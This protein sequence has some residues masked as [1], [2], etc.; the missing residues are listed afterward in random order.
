MPRG[1]ARPNSGPKKGTRYRMTIGREAP[2]PEFR[3][4]TEMRVAARI[5]RNIMVEE[6]NAKQAGAKNKKALQEA[7]KDYL[8]ALKE[9]VPYED[10]RLLAVA[11]APPPPDRL[12]GDNARVINLRIF[13]DTGTAAGLLEAID[14]QAQFTEV[15]DGRSSVPD[16]S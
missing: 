1:G 11:I 7:T 2:V 10:P 5:L 3:A 8:R 14:G 12:P 16:D 13:E 6:I 15:D 9:I 4:L